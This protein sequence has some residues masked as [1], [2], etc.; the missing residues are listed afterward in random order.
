VPPDL[1]VIIASYNSRRTIGRCLDSLRAQETGRAFEVI[2]VDSSTDGAAE[3]IAQ[4]HPEVVLITSAERRFPG[5]ARNIGVSAASAGI[6]ALLDADCT[7][8]PGW[9]DA[10]LDAHRSPDAA[11]GGVIANGDRRGHVARAAYFTEFSQWMPGERPGW[12]TDVAAANISY[13]REVFDDVGPFIEGAYCSDTDFHWR[14]HR[15]GHRLRF[16]PSIVAYH[17]SISELGAFL[18][19]ERAHGRFFARVRSA[20]QGFSAARRIIYAGLCWLIPFV[21]FAKLVRRHQRNRVYLVDFLASSPLVLLGLTAWAL[22]EG[23]G[24][25]RG[26]CIRGEP[27]QD[28]SP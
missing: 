19:H 22:G 15:K 16:E 7:V 25:V 3:L 6:V 8:D 17:H 26:P 2:V 11:I 5:G 28:V 18:R 24:Y 9:V 4:D 1:S 23:A 12:M 10:V 27:Q 21:L 20:G 14:M 13:K